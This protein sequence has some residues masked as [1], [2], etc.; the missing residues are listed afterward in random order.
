MVKLFPSTQYPG[1][2][3]ARTI[4]RPGFSPHPH[5]SLKKGEGGSSC[6]EVSVSVK[7]RN[8]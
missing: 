8:K 4:V 3:P 6:Q 1:P 5:L 2:I 7:T